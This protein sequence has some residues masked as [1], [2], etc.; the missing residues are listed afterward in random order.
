MDAWLIFVLLI[1]TT[2]ILLLLIFCFVYVVAD[3]IVSTLDDKTSETEKIVKDL[4]KKLNLIHWFRK[5]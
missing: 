5:L 2:A 3:E 4:S 1:I